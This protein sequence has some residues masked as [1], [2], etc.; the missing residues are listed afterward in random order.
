MQA[1]IV[2][3]VSMLV[4]LFAAMVNAAV[5]YQLKHADSAEIA[6][7][8]IMGIFAAIFGWLGTVGM[9]I[10]LIYVVSLPGPPTRLDVLIIAGSIGGLVFVGTMQVFKQFVRRIESIFDRM[11]R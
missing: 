3:V 7:W 1:W 10:N 4:A 5:N 9:V 6:K 11:P 8:K 2:A